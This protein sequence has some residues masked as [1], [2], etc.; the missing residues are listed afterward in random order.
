MSTRFPAATVP[1]SEAD[2]DFV[3]EVDT[4]SGH[5][6]TNPRTVAVVTDDAALRAALA[7]P[8][9]RAGHAV[10][11]PDAVNSAWIILVDGSMSDLQSL[12]HAIAATRRIARNDAAIVVILEHARPDFVAAAHRAG[13]FACLRAPF[14]EEELVAVIDRTV[15]SQSAKL[16]AADV[17]QQ[18]NLQTHLASLGRMSAGLS[19]ELGTRLAVVSMCLE[20]I[21]EDVCA[22]LREHAAV[23]AVVSAPNAATPAALAALRSAH[24]AIDPDRI[25]ESLHDSSAALTRTQALLATLRE[26][27]RGQPPRSQEAL[28]LAPLVRDVRRWLDPKLLAEVDLEIVIDNETLVAFATATLVEQLLVN[29][30]TNG[31]HAAQELSSPRLRVHL[32]STDQEVIVSV[33]DNGPGITPDMQAKIFEPFFTTKRASGGTGLGLS[34]CREYALQ[35]GARISVWSVPGRGA[36]FRVHLRR[37]C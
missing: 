3:D 34:L 14:V 15:D 17:S 4:P 24:D 9:R 22:L 7:V 25:R 8:L 29:L 31:I 27:V 10:A 23:G 11:G 12:Q 30:V 35:M 36:C 2:D 33:R 16:H 20:A 18:L 13:A 28:M 37:A 6:G 1:P 5:F 26:L 32:Y 21:D 19:H